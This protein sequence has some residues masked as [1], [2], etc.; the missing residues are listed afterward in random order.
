MRPI[1]RVG[2]GRIGLADLVSTGDVM[3]NTP[4]LDLLR[5]VQFRRQFHPERAVGD[6]KFGT[7]EN[8]RALV[9]RAATADA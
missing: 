8:I 9:R 6:A 7:I 3:D 5:R 2:W 4:M 1:S